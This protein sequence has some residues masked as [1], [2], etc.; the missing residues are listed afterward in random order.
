MPHS[1]L[2]AIKAGL[3]DYEPAPAE[4]NEFASTDAMPGSEAKLKVL[5]DRIAAGLP[6]WHESDRV[7]YDDP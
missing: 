1:V 2:E 6:L 5:A 3:W 4:P 7:T